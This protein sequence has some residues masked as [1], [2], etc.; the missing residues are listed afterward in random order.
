MIIKDIGIDTLVADAGYKTPAIAKMLL[1]DGIKPLFPYTRP[2]T[3]EGF[4]KKYEYAYGEYYDCY[5]CPN[6]EVLRYSTTNRAGYREYKSCGQ[7]C[8]SCEYLSQCTHSKE[9]VK[10]MPREKRR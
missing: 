8:G 10:L 7:V 9:Q 3:K 2:M 1:D 4:F 5:V 6:N